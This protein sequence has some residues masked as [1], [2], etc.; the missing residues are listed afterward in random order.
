MPRTPAEGEPNATTEPEKRKVPHRAQLEQL[1]N[2]PKPWTKATDR[3]GA[4]DHTPGPDNGHLRS[5]VRVV[6]LRSGN[7]GGAEQ[8]LY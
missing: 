8:G 1:P 5:E 4:V 3:V 2:L 7:G 6:F